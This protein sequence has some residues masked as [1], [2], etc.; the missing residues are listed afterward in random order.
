V[1]RLR[2]R[3]RARAA[4]HLASVS[5]NERAALES[6]LTRGAVPGRLDAPTA[7]APVRTVPREGASR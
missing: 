2:G 6:L 1:E 3:M 5:A 4:T 7:F